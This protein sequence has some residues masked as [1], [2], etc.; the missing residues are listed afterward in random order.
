MREKAWG[1]IGEP[2]HFTSYSTDSL[3]RFGIGSCDDRL[4]D[5]G[6]IDRRRCHGIDVAW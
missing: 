6:R 1:K 5:V 2:H 3:V 4:L